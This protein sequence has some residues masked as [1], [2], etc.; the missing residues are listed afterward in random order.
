MI[1]L[2][3]GDY[4]IERLEIHS[5]I[6]TKSMQELTQEE[7]LGTNDIAII[8]LKLNLQMIYDPYVF[9]KVMGSLIVIHTSTNATAAAGMID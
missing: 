5:V 6:D 8:T 2:V 3:S 7:A 4:P 1:Q 9:N